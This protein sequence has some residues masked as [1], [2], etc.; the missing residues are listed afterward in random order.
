MKQSNLFNFFKAP[1]HATPQ[2]S[3]HRDP[4]EEMSDIKYKILKRSIIHDIAE[5]S[6]VDS[7]KSKYQ[8]Q[9]SPESPNTSTCVSS[10]E[11]E[12]SCQKTSPTTNDSD[13]PIQISMESSFAD[14]NLDNSTLSPPHEDISIIPEGIDYERIRMENIQKN[15]EFLFQLGL[16][17]LKSNLNTNVI[18]NQ[19]RNIKKRKL[20]K[21]NDN[22]MDH[23]QGMRRSSRLQKNP[24][25]SSYEAEYSKHDHLLDDEEEENPDHISSQNEITYDDSAVL[26][27]VMTTHASNPTDNTTNQSSTSSIRSVTGFKLTSDIPIRSHSLEAIYSMQFHPLYPSLLLAAG[28]KGIISLFNLQYPQNHNHSIGNNNNN[29][30]NNNNSNSSLLDFQA[31]S[32]W[33]S[34]AKFL[35]PFLSHNDSDKSKCANQLMEEN[36]PNNPMNE[37]SLP[38]TLPLITASDDAFIKIWDLAK[39]SVTRD[40]SHQPY[41]LCKDNMIHDRGI[42]SLDVV[43]DD[44]ITGSKD[45]TVAHTKIVS[46]NASLRKIRSYEFHSGVVKCVCWRMDSSPYVDGD[47]ASSVAESNLLGTV[48]ASASSDRTVCIK[49]VRTPSGDSADIRLVDV[50]HGSAHSVVWSPFPPTSHLFVTSG[51][52]DVIKAYDLRKLSNNNNDNNNNQ[53]PLYMYKG[54]SNTYIRKFKSIFVPKFIQYNIIAVCGEGSNEL[55]LYNLDTGDTISRGLLPDQPMVITASYT[56]DMKCNS[57]IVDNKEKY[58]NENFNFSRNVAVACKKLASIYSLSLF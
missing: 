41:L 27:Y 44:V 49:D 43:G 25:P 11:D 26:K 58:V 57:S 32:R 4:L 34:G 42:F 24:P 13:F 31:H 20:L 23:P 2:K 39:C 48:F 16:T 6:A 40:G 5:N 52:D 36:T 30:N 22:H 15:N 51:L 46:N 10:T 55:S 28:K 37:H 8:L 33:I 9:I 54:H 14:N 35:I 17:E 29:N 47:T 19:N 12:N 18:T 56:T 38:T 3:S 50:H 1:K 21:P 7:Q 45:C 53:K